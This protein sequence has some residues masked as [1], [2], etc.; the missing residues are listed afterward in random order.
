MKIK[1][2]KLQDQ[3]DEAIK[4]KAQHEAKA[5]RTM[6]LAVK[7]ALVAYMKKHK[8]GFNEVVRRLNCTPDQIAKIKRGA[9]NLTLTSIAHLS[10]LFEEEPIIIFKKKST[11]PISRK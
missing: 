2:Y 3:S 8:V 6:Q 11:Q 7:R 4:R 5:L 9:A 1:S 10:A